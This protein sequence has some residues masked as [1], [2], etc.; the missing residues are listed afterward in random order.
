VENQPGAGGVL[1]S[2]LCLVGQ[3]G[4]GVAIGDLHHSPGEV[5]E[6]QALHDRQ[7]DYEKRPQP[8]YGVGGEAFHTVTKWETDV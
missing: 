5:G 1:G 8:P 7:Q 2:D 4:K 6:H 3:N